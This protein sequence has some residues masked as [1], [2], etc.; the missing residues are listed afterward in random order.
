MCYLIDVTRSPL[1]EVDLWLSL[2]WY[3]ARGEEYI[4]SFF[5]TYPCSY[6]GTTA[7]G[8]TPAPMKYGFGFDGV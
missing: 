2:L 3:G 7:G 6:L 1:G 4:P 5:Q 8:R